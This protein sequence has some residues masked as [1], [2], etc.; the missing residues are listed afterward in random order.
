MLTQLL[1]QSVESNKLTPLRF[2]SSCKVS[3]IMYA[4]DILLYFRVSQK[5]CLTIKS[6]FDKYESL[7][8]QRVNLSKSAIYFTKSTPRNTRANTY[9]LLG[10]KEDQFPLKYLGA[11][12][13]PRRPPSSSHED[14]HLKCKSKLASW[15]CNYLPQAGQLVVIKSILN[16]IPIHTLSINWLPKSTPRKVKTLTKNFL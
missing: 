7:T 3:H 1:S 8:N 10:F 16:S 14:L 11:Y 12:F 15:Q 2:D 6:I 5:S 13:S 4:D 9:S